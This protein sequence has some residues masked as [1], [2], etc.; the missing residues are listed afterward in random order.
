MW[1]ELRLLQAEHVGVRGGDK[2]KKTLVDAG[3][4]TVDIP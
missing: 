2:I 4:Q 1:L 3:A